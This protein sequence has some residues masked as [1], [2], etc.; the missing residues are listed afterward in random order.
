MRRGS[1]NLPLT[2]EHLMR[3][4]EKI[5]EV[6]YPEMEEEESSGRSPQEDWIWHRNESEE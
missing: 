1:T 5:K 6:G 2:A 3:Y 4:K